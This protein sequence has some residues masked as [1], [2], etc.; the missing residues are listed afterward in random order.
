MKLRSFLTI[1][2][3]VGLVYAVGLLLMPAFVATMYGLGTSASEILLARL[4]GGTLLAVVL[5]QWLARDFTGA[6]VRPVLVGSLVGEAVGLIVALVGVLAGTMNSFGWSAVVI[7]L[8]F[9]LGF[10]Y[11]QFMGAPE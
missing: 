6:T 8:V 4:F 10:A 9:G 3:V 2:A 7:Y 1:T 11:Y 5:I